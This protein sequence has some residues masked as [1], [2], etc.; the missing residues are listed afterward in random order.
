MNPVSRVGT[1]RAVGLAKHVAHPPARHQGDDLGEGVGL[2]SG[3]RNRQPAQQQPDA[4]HFARG[5]AEHCTDCRAV[6]E[7]THRADAVAKGDGHAG[8]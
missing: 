8:T 4:A 6:L 7:T 3:E 2:E 1:N 5:G